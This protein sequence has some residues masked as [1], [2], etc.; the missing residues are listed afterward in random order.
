[1]LIGRGSRDAARYR[2]YKG[3]APDIKPVLYR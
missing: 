1:V 3:P 2:R